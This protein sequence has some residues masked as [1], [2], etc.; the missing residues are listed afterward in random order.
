MN[1]RLWTLVDRLYGKEVMCKGRLFC[2]YIPNP[3]VRSLFE[4]QSALLEDV[5]KEEFVVIQVLVGVRWINYRV[6]K[7]SNGSS[8]VEFLSDL[9]DRLP[10]KKTA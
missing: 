9:N 4:N 8:V 3:T 6:I 5:I 7:E 2:V 10:R 1:Y